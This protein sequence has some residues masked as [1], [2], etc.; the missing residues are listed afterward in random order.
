[1]AYSIS[2]RYGLAYAAM[3]RLSVKALLMRLQC[4]IICLFGG[5]KNTRDLA[6]SM[7]KLLEFDN[8]SI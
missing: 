7:W 5:P 3:W 6:K 1:M 4:Y 8:S 2:A